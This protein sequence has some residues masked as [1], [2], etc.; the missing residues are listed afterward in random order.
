MFQ[1]CWDKIENYA[2]EEEDIDEEDI[3]NITNEH[4]TIVSTNYTTVLD[5]AGKVLMCD[6]RN[7]RKLID[8]CYLYKVLDAICLYHNMTVCKKIVQSF[9]CSTSVDEDDEFGFHIVYI[10]NDSTLT[11]RYFP[12]LHYAN[13][14]MNTSQNFL[15]NHS[16]F[17]I[18][19]FLVES[20]QS[21]HSSN[22]INIIER[23]F[24]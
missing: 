3:K 10:T 15:G 6:L 24:F 12:D 21:D 20:M 5:C 22:A 19:D 8:V 9:V 23:S 2:D 16:L 14:T 13:F 1:D 18:F 17:Q 7:I 11:L 4:V